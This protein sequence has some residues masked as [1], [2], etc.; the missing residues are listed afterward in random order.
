MA[1]REKPLRVLAIDT[2]SNPGYAVYEVRKG[3]PKLVAV[4]SVKTNS[5]MTD[6]QRYAVV[7]A[8][9]TQVV[10]KH[11]PF[12]VVCR[13]HFLKAGNKRGTQMVFGSWAAVD[14]A[15]ATFGYVI[16]EEDEINNTLVK[17]IVGSHGES[18][19]KKVEEGIRKILDLPEDFEFKNDDESDAAAIGYT[20]LLE[21]GLIHGEWP[22]GKKRRL[23]TTFP[24]VSA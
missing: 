11:G 19:K 22:K 15:L 9:T 7:E 18:D 10:H 1:T 5:G 24:I 23:S 21:K 3:V 13:E 6:A 16:D 12:D 17:Q 20:F 4:S 2:S 14:R 8:A